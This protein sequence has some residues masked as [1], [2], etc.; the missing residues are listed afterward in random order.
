MHRRRGLIAVYAW[1][2]A[3]AGCA[4][5][6]QPAADTTAP[7]VPPP[8]ARVAATFRCDDGS[9]VQ[10]DFRNDTI[11]RIVVLTI[12]DDRITLPQQRSADGARYADSTTEFWNKG[13]DASFTRSGGHTT[14]HSALPRAG[15]ASL[16]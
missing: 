11:P 13:R 14:C 6:P 8:P 12:G 16:P 7:A 15:G 9:V 1:A 3:F 2:A 10:A 5:E 4:R